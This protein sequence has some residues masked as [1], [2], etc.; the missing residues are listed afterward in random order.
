MT[1]GSSFWTLIVD[2]MTNGAWLVGAWL[3]ADGA[4]AL[5]D[6]A[7]DGAVA[8]ADGAVVAVVEPHAATSSMTAATAMRRGRG[9]SRR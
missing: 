1:C 6:G 9:A 7:L 5:P 8:E 4:S 3:A 2:A